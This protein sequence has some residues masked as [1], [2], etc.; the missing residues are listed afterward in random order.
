MSVTFTDILPR[1]FRCILHHQKAFLAVL[2]PPTSIWGNLSLKIW[3]KV[4]LKITVSK[5][6]PDRMNHGKS[7]MRR[8]R[9]CLNQRL[10]AQEAT[11]VAR[12]F[13][14]FV[15]EDEK[16]ASAVQ[17]LLQAELDLREGVFL[18]SDK[19]QIYAGDLWLQKIK[20]ALS[21]AEIVILMLSKRSVAR[22]WVNFEAG[23]AWL[24]DKTLIPVCYGNLS[25]NVLPHPYSGIQALNLQSEAYYL[26]KS[27]THQLNLKPMSPSAV[28]GGTLSEHGA[29]IDD[30]AYGRLA[31]ALSE[32]KDD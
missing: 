19:S 21:S 28:Y 13:V 5:S 20:E 14:S 3:G 15:H 2:L 9:R 31:K 32:F 12:I 24:V 23:A 10:H 4:I 29:G 18:S 27:V 22:P 8:M 6:K 7:H 11:L 17:D 30:S 1:F 26:L 25:K 16:I